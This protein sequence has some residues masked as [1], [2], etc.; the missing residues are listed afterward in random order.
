LKFIWTIKGSKLEFQYSECKWLRAW[1]LNVAEWKLEW[2]LATEAFAAD[3]ELITVEEM[4]GLLAKTEWCSS[5][6][7]GSTVIFPLPEYMTALLIASNVV[8]RVDSG[9]TQFQEYDSW[10]T[11]YIF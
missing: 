4:S 5:T 11:L 6:I 3:K 8:K 9:E 10:G 7:K 2:K 1:F